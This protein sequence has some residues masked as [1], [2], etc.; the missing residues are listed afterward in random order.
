MSYT[1]P[2]FYNETVSFFVI[3]ISC[4]QLVLSMCV[5]IHKYIQEYNQKCISLEWGI[6][7]QAST[8]S[9]SR[10]YK[11]VIAIYILRLEVGK[12]GARYAIVSKCSLD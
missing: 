2:Q 10:H 7:M 1:L 4:Y 12:L 11:C 6:E 3:V 9:I 5:H 8:I